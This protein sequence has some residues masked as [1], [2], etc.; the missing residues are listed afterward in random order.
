MS[1]QRFIYPE[2]FTSH[3]FMSLSHGARLLFIGM[4]TTADDFGRGDASPTVLKAKVFPGDDARARDIAGWLG[5]IADLG[6]AIVYAPRESTPL[7]RRKADSGLPRD[8]AVSH[9]AAV[10]D[11]AGFRRTVWHRRLEK[12]LLSRGRVYYQLTAWDKYQNPRYKAKSKTPEF[13]AI[14][15]EN[16]CGTSAEPTATLRRTPGGPDT[17]EGRGVV[18]VVEG[19]GGVGSGGEALPV[20]GD[21]RTDAIDPPLDGPD[22][23]DP[24]ADLPPSMRRTPEQREAAEHALATLRRLQG[25]TGP[26]DTEAA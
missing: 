9:G 18:G 5:Q 15:M 26:D 23:P 13:R 4:F 14:T 24:D 16:L 17:V 22:R 6:M 11:E 19:S 3:D 12:T 2:I 8:S 10:T 20:A 7:S 25:A 21:A 1:R